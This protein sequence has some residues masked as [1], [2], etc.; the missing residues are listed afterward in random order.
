MHSLCIVVGDDPRRALAPFSDHLKVERYR[1]YLEPSAV[2][3]M[4]EHRGVA[5]DDLE[6]LAPRLREWMGAEGGVHDG[7]LFVWT[8][9][10]P[11][12]RY[13]WYR[14]GGRFSG[15]LRLTSPA[16]TTWRDRLRGRTGAYSADRAR[17]GDV[18]ARAILAD[19][20]AALLLDG[21]RHECPPTAEEGEARRWAE[22]CAALLDAVPDGV[23]L[24]VV[25]LHS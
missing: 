17:K 19:P 22:E 10:N 23:L 6:A 4:A 11:R 13:D 3:A 8:T 18:D 20:P 21:A 14:L 25:D 12:G 1:A 16:A 15:Y 24:T 9:E 2:A 7:R 5:A